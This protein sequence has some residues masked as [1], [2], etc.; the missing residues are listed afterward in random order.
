LLMLAKQYNFIWGT[1][2]LP[3]SS[4]PRL[5]QIL[6]TPLET[7]GLKIPDD[8]QTVASRI[9]AGKQDA[10]TR[11]AWAN[12]LIGSLLI[13]GILPRLLLLSLSLVMQKWSEYRFKLDLYLPYYI[14]LRQ[15]LMARE[16]K[17][18]VIDADPN[19]GIKPAEVT[20]PPENVSIPANAQAFGIELDQA[21]LWPES[22][23]CR[24]N[25][26]DQQSHDEAIALIKNVKGPLLLGVAAHR[27]PDRGV[28]RLIKELVDST[29]EKPWLILLT[30][31]SAPVAS[32]REFAWFRLAEACSIPA[33]HVIT[34]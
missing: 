28:Q 15:R 5:T 8:P 23:T 26:I 13:Y 19:A 7:M 1:T 17:A 4:L 20:R 22:V 14:E 9:G 24:L 2:L 33:E 3:D 31:P 27:L 12:F 16:L 18:K 21:T 6:G 32:A 11:G 10:E 34:Q 29:A 30:K 25:I